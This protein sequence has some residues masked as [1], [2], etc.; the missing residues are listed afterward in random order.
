MR[1]IFQ[2]TALTRLPSA[3]LTVELADGSRV[4]LSQSRL[5][6]SFP[7][8]PLSKVFDDLQVKSVALRDADPTAVRAFARYLQEGQGIQP[9]EAP[10]LLLFEHA[11]LANTRWRQAVVQQCAGAFNATNVVA[12]WAAA[13]AAL[14][15][16]DADVEPWVGQ[17]QEAAELWMFEHTQ[18][19]DTIDDSASLLTEATRAT[20][21]F[22]LT[23]RWAQ[24][25]RRIGGPNPET[26][27]D[28]LG[29]W[30]APYAQ[31]LTFLLPTWNE[32]QLTRLYPDFLFSKPTMSEQLRAQATRLAAV[33]GFQGDPNP[34]LDP[35][36]RC[37]YAH[38]FQCASRI[39]DLDDVA[40]L[41]RTMPPSFVALGKNWPVIVAYVAVITNRSY[42]LDYA[43][44]QA[45]SETL[46]HILA[47]FASTWPFLTSGDDLRRVVALYSQAPEP[48]QVAR[49]IFSSAVQAG[50]QKVAQWS[51]QRLRESGSAKQA[52]ADV[53][54]PRVHALPALAQTLSQTELSALHETQGEDEPEWAQIWDCRDHDLV[55][56]ELVE[57]CTD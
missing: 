40:F 30:L 32:D 11:Y 57:L 2:P 22:R 26:T 49:T 3:S 8:A 20:L 9:P 1:P 45:D 41:T 16:S 7:A 56:T 13:E 52:L 44:R 53:G 27:R 35:R 48:H 33:V 4:G 21:Q 38:L 5:A 12:T 10:A 55:M 17:L 25:L 19:L 28:L 47:P 18:W 23:R 15:A 29:D 6:E 34:R 39:G 46:Q 50:A 36:Y 51:L 31:L 24:T 54:A 43:V 37:Q 14:Q 42:M